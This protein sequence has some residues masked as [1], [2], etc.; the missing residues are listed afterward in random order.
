M[1][2]LRS[3]CIQCLLKKVSDFPETA[4]EEFR[5]DYIQRVLGILAD[6][7]REVS[8][9]EVVWEISKVRR[10]MFGPN[11]EYA[12]LKHRF[13]ELMMNCADS[14]RR[15]IRE[16]ADPLFTAVRCSLAGNYIDFGA[17]DNVSEAELLTMLQNADDIPLDPA[18]CEE[19]RSQLAAAKRMVF[20]TDNC[21]EVVLDKLLLEE[22][23]R[24]HPELS[25]TI[26]VRGEP[27]LNDATLE[28]ARQIGLFEA[29][30]V[31]GNGNG[32]AGTCLEQLS[33]EAAQAVDDADLIIAKG[34][35]NFE[36]LRGCGKN[37][38]YLFLCKCEMFARQFGVKQMTGMLTH[39]RL[40]EQEKR[41]MTMNDNINI[42]LEPALP[43]DLDE[44]C[45][46][47]TKVAKLTPNS[48]WDD[49]YPNREILSDDIG[50]KSLYKILHEGK[51]ISIMQ[52][53]PWADQLANEPEMAAGS[54][55]ASI[56]NPCGLGRFCV[57]P[58]L[59][60]QGL[61]RR[62]MTAS[63]EKARSMG[64]DGAFFQAVK[65][66]ST[67]IHLY[68]SMGFHRTGEQHAYGLDFV[69]FEMK[70]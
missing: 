4:P 64:Y 61:G 59:Q 68:D 28:D 22:I 38:Y 11:E 33:E 50:C 56:Q 30:T 57:T 13:N 45:A 7:P 1:N 49:E 21:G 25:I 41:R 16:S 23:R 53:R 15:R 58:D 63:L 27:V 35:G 70:F 52:I 60:G 47:C 66:N 62:V 6:A 20:L 12:Q 48:Y 39:D 69:M 17:L 55:D 36:T 18:L 5:L 19:L 31:L 43:E 8:A 24:Q 37:I 44:I 10:E 67:A 42:C 54:W 3:D 51:I 26:L 32:V 2:R 40:V 46:L 65:P 29:G 9:P 34:Q 14:I